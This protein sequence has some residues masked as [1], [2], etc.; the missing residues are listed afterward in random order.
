MKLMLKT[1]QNGIFF[2]FTMSLRC[3]IYNYSSRKASDE[4]IRP[5]TLHSSCYECICNEMLKKCSNEMLF[6]RM[7]KRECFLVIFAD[8]IEFNAPLPAASSSNPA[9]GKWHCAHRRSGSGTIP[10]LRL[11][12][13]CLHSRHCLPESTGKFTISLNPLRP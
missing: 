3:F 13:N 4:R 7:L 6:E 10:H 8:R 2:W 12:R 5:I 1:P 11:P 9:D